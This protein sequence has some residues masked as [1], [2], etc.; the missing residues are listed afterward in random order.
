MS[1]P[2][3]LV[4][5]CA[6]F[7]LATSW[8]GFIL[9]PELQLGAQPQAVVES[10]GEY[11]PSLRPGM[12]RQ[13]EQVYKQNG[14]NYCHSQ[15]VRPKGFG[16]DVERQWG[17]RPGKVQSVN[18]DYLYD[19][20]VMLGDMRIGPDL[21]NYG[22][23]QTNAAIIF[24]HLYNP[25]LTMPGS[26]MPAYRFLF[27]THKLK[28][29]AQPSKEALQ[30]GNAAPNGVE[31][32]PT[33]DARALAAYLISLHSDALIFDTPPGPKTNAAPAAAA[34]AAT[35]NAPATNSPAK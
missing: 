13:G 14:C 28:P 8:V 21:A 15:Q 34:A 25:R 27:D 5:L 20:T 16:S 19:R 9:A 11:Y 23:R 35:T 33:D 31:V 7:A 24:Q 26:V 32:V 18:E 2:G 3:P 1:T 29:G 10:T 12:A 22:L 6:F 30:L 4:F 17:G